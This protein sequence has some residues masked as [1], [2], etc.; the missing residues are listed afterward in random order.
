VTM[1]RDSSFQPLR[2]DILSGETENR[3]LSGADM[4][5]HQRAG[6]AGQGRRRRPAGVALTGA[7]DGALDLK[8]S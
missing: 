7:K 1:A 6:R 2:G 4:R 5:P 3:I 8:R